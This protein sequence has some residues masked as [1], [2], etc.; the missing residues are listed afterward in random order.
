MRPNAVGQEGWD[1]SESYPIHRGGDDVEAGN[2]EPGKPTLRSTDPRFPTSRA[3]RGVTDQALPPRQTRFSLMQSPR[4][5]V[6]FLR[7][8]ELT[9]RLRQSLIRDTDDG[10][11]K[12]PVNL[13]YE[14]SPDMWVEAS[15]NPDYGIARTEW[16]L[17]VRVLE[18][19][20]RDYALFM[21]VGPGSGA[22]AAACIDELTSRQVRYVAFDINDKMME[23]AQQTITTYANDHPEREVSRQF[24]KVDFEDRGAI[25]RATRPSDIAGEKTL[26][27]MLGQTFGNPTPQ[28]RKNMLDNI[29]ACAPYGARLMMGVAMAPPDRAAIDNTLKGYRSDAYTKL[30]TAPL[31]RLGIADAGKLEIIWNDE[32]PGIEG[33]FTLNKDVVIDGTDISLAQGEQI[34]AF[35]SLRFTHEGLKAALE[36][37]GFAE[38]AFEDADSGTYSVVTAVVAE[39]SAE[40][41]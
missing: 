2:R 12:I 26:I 24:K 33:I 4:T 41:P 10:R 11:W 15:G 27:A 30:I 9:R 3:P 39:R 5:V 23:L 1:A 36:A 29:H 17:I 37:A 19:Y 31:R 6:S 21:E 35:T 7:E 38:V 25:S 8:A 20:G 18:K 40:A 34:V 28:G 22:K 14:L 13:Q 32:A 16:E